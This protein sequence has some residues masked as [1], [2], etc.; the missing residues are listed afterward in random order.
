MKNIYIAPITGN[1]EITGQ[2]T[3]LLQSNDV[4]PVK[5]EMLSDINLLI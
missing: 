3:I 2:A 5:D 1:M 4:I